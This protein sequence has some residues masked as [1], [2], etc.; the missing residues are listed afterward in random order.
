MIYALFV[1]G[2]RGGAWRLD[3]GGVFGGDAAFVCAHSGGMACSV[4]FRR[5]LR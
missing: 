4:Q 2:R 5:V 3:F 1:D